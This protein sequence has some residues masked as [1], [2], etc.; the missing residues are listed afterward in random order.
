MATLGNLGIGRITTCPRIDGQT[1][2]QTLGTVELRLRS[3]K[4][5]QEW[6]AY[7]CHGLTLSTVSQVLLQVQSSFINFQRINQFYNLLFLKQGIQ[8]WAQKSSQQNSPA[9]GKNYEK[10]IRK[11]LFLYFS[12][13]FKEAQFSW[14]GVVRALKIFTLTLENNIIMK[15]MKYTW[16]FKIYRLHITLNELLIFINRDSI[17]L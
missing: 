9:D 7:L 1:D 4:K 11:L 15:Y 5:N 16:C 8:N 2:R 17:I 6:V 14:I 3:L 10:R 12:D 13:P